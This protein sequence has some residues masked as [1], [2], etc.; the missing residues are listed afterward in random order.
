MIPTGGENVEVHHSIEDIWNLAYKSGGSNRDEKSP[1]DLW[2]MLLME[3]EL[4]Y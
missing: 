2:C 1:R 3:L 4:I